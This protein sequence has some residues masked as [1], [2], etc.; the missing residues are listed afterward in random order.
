VST[1]HA[2]IAVAV[3]N[4]GSHELLRRH[5]PAASALPDARIVVVDN[6]STDAERAAVT[7]LAAERDWELVTLPDNGGFARGV[8]AS[9]ARA[10]ELGACAVLLL[11]P[12]AQISPQAITELGD[13]LRR[14]PKAVVT[15]RIVDSSGVTVFDGSELDVRTGRLAR[16]A[17]PHA[18]PWLTAACLAIHL[19]LFDRLGGMD[20]S[21]FL[22]WEDVDF[23]YRA[24]AAGAQ[25]VVR[26]DL[27]AVHDEGGTQGRSGRA[28]S[29]GYYRYNARNRLRF[30]ASNLTRAE[31]LRWLLH[32]PAESTQ[33]LLRGGR[34]QLIESPRPLVAI[35]R[36]SLEGIGLALWALVRGR[37][38]P[39]R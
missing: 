34:R 15:P 18:V 16:H 35:L 29:A 25:L 24:A 17:G 8:N 11:N 27:V 31:V 3:V 14:D 21:Y 12:D 22:Y 4:Y 13:H 32:T 33:I 23:S 7:A 20:E 36:G 28:K 39:G 9:A 37:R 10:R 2:P 5:L 1:E 6:F 26:A 30:A 38:D 19:E